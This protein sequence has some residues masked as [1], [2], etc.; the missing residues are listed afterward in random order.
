MSEKSISNNYS[1]YLTQIVREI[2][3]MAL[4]EEI[5]VFLPVH[6]KKKERKSDS[7]DLEDLK[8]SS[9]PG[10]EADLVFLLERERNL[11]KN[12]DSYFTELT[13]IFLAKNRR[14]GITKIGK[15]TMFNGRFVP[16][17]SERKFKEINAPKPKV[18]EKTEEDKKEEVT[19]KEI[20][21]FKEDEEDEI[22][23][24]DIDKTW[25]NL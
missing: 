6:M 11:D 13:R 9:G 10:Q 15:F 7:V 3:T 16:D 24:E 14:T 18:E 19:Q 5:I 17:E 20:P 1:T 25:N 4:Q 2:K 8:D 22:T 23:I 12:A 21:I